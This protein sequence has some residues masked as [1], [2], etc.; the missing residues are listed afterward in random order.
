MGAVMPEFKSVKIFLC[1]AYERI[2]GCGC[3]L[4]LEWSCSSDAYKG[5][6]NWLMAAFYS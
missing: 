2:T 4:I 5:L 6:R 1:K 3:G